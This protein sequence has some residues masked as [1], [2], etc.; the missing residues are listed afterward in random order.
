MILFVGSEEK[1]HFI[2]EVAKSY[3]WNAAF[4]HPKLD[5]FS[6]VQEILQYPDC[7]VIV[8]DVEQ[9]V[10]NAQE[11]AIVENEFG[12]LFYIEDMDEGMAPAGTVVEDG[13]MESI[14]N[15]RKVDRDAILRAFGGR[16]E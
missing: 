4:V 8:Y 10:M 1:G 3:Q 15:L 13:L 5:I 11:M 2:R 16:E 7:K 12:T 6:Q 9:Y 14:Q